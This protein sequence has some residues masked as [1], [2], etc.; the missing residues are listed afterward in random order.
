MAELHRENWWKAQKLKI[1]V[2]S[3][4]LNSLFSHGNDVISMGKYIFLKNN[5]KNDSL[6]HLVARYRENSNIYEIPDMASENPQDD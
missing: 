5:D 1:A 3:E 4:N 2:F 6:G